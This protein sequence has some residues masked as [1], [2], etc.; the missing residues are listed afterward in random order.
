MNCPECE[1]KLSV[2]GDAQEG[3]MVSCPDCGADYEVTRE[4]G[5]LGLKNA[6]SVGEDWG[7]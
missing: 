2:P 6:E 5:G 1:A 7:E 4:N 3:E